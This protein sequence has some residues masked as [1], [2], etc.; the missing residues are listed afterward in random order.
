MAQIDDLQAG[1]AANAQKLVDLTTVV[2]TLAGKVDA[3]IAKGTGTA[4]DLTPAIAAEAGEGTSL[5]AVTAAA[6]AAVDKATAA[7]V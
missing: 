6:Q 5:D 1:Q 7:G 3:L 2:T 4:V